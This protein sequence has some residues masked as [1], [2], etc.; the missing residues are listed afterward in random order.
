VIEAGETVVFLALGA[1]G[2]RGGAGD[3]ALIGEDSCPGRRTSLYTPRF[4][5]NSVV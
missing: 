2:K 3:G 5:K 4:P 1:L